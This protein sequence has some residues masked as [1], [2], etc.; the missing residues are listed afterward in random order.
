M[1]RQWSEGITIT[2]RIVQMAARMYV[3]PVVEPM[4]CGDSYGYRPNKSA[5]DAVAIARKKCRSYDYVIERDV[6]GI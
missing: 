4:F 3:E 1:Q 2:D 5:I 6:K